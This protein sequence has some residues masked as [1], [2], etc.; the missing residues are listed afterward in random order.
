MTASCTTIGHGRGAAPRTGLSAVRRTVLDEPL[1]DFFFDPSL[2]NLIGARARR[3]QSDQ[4]VNLDVR[5]KIATL[6]LPGLPHLG[7]G[8]T[9]Q[10]N[11]RPVLATPESE[12][13]RRDA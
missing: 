9:W 8:I 2:R 1:D 12:G 4:V 11:G 3:R 10:W 5:R 13:R 6:D 7:S